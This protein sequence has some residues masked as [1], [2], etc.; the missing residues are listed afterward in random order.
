MP[1]FN[2]FLQKLVNETPEEQEAAAHNHRVGKEYT[3]IQLRVHDAIL[4]GISSKLLI[5]VKTGLLTVPEIPEVLDLVGMDILHLG[6][7]IRK[8]IEDAN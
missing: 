6:N 5:L 4:N 8:D 7:N 3:E 1:D 2:E